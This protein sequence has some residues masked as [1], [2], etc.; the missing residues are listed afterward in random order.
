[1]ADEKFSED[2]EEPTKDA[3]RAEPAVG[4]P[5]TYGPVA[6]DRD[7]QGASP[8]EPRGAP[9]DEPKAV[10]PIPSGH[11]AADREV[12]PR[13]GNPDVADVRT[14]PEPV[15][16]ATASG[17]AG[18]DGGSEGDQAVSEGAEGDRG[19][20]ERGSGV[21]VAG[22]RGADEPDQAEADGAGAGEGAGDGWRA[23]EVRRPR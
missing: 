1:M 7:E 23:A 15:S 17:G 4:T 8:D 5:A 2:D 10:A 22:G 16:G 6:E 20:A 21:R 18:V 14:S 9:D 11:A 12:E 19:T 3:H 13:A